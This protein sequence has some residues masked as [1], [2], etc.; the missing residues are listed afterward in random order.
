MYER[1]FLNGLETRLKI[2]LD[3][4]DEWSK[5]N[6]MITPFIK[7]RLKYDHSIQSKK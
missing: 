1:A 7:E 3:M 2:M 5:Y 4:I 6:F